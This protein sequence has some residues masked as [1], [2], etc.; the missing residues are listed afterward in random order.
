MIATRVQRYSASSRRCVV[1]RTGVAL[2]LI[3]SS[4]CLLA[5]GSSPTVGSSKNANF[6]AVIRV[7]AVLNFLLFPPLSIRACF[8][9]LSSSSREERALNLLTYLVC[10]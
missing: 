2:L 6:G 4:S 9:G 3:K 8:S 10:P 7:I 1:K 5:T